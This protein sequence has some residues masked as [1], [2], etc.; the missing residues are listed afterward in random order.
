MLTMPL[1]LYVVRLCSRGSKCR[2]SVTALANTS[3]LLGVEGMGLG[4]GRWPLLILVLLLQLNFLLLHLL[5]VALLRGLVNRYVLFLICLIFAYVYT[6]C[7]CLY[8]TLWLNNVY[9][10]LSVD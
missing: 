8:C 2:G 7:E 10:E 9:R 6:I 4:W 1:C 5:M 3:N